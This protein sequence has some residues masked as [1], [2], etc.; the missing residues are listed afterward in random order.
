MDAQ[1]FGAFI[2]SRRKKLGMNQAQL[3]ETL[4]VTAKAVS[5]WERGVGFPNIEL[6]QP[7]AEALE[8]TLVELMQ[9]RRMEAELTKEEAGEIVTQSVESIRAL[10]RKQRRK[11]YS[12]FFLLPTIFG[13][14]LFLL[15]VYNGYSFDSRWARLLFY[16]I[17]I[18]G[19]A[20]G[21]RAVYYIIW[22]EYGKLRNRGGIRKGL[23]TCVILTIT[24]FFLKT[25]C[26]VWLL[27]DGLT[28]AIFAGIALALF[29]AC[30]FYFLHGRGQKS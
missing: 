29:I 12:L 25:G 4:H 17:I 21:V 11:I 1:V 19:G 3:A 26:S 28:A 9:S 30:Y 10:E 24:V 23:L 7:L 2:Q 27:G 15:H 16:E 22:N 6:L 14:Q 5:R 18:L 8:I 13:A 20:W